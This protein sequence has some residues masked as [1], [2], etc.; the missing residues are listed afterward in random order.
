MN[1]WTKQSARNAALDRG[2]SVSHPDFPGWL[3]YVRPT[4]AWNVHYRRAAMR[5]ALSDPA[6]GDYLDRV[7]APGYVLNAAD[8]ELDAQMQRDGFAEG[9]LGGWEGVTDEDGAPLPFTLANARKLLNHFRQLFDYLDAFSRKPENYPA[10]AEDKKAEIALGNS[11][12]ASLSPSEAGGNI[13]NSSL[14]AKTGEKA[15]RAKS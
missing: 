4:N 12:P 13:S 8:Q 11:Q 3:F 15:R 10:L 14:P 1:F 6:I 2:V 7:N 9:N 5:L